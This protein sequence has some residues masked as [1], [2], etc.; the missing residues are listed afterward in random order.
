VRLYAY[1]D[2]SIDS[3]TK[4]VN[5]HPLP[6]INLGSD[7]V[8]CEGDN[9]TLDAGSGF[10]SYLWQNGNTTQSIIINNGG[11]FWVEVS[12]EF[13]CINR[14]S[15][16]LSL[17]PENYIYADTG[18]CLGDSI[19][20]GGSF[21][22]S[23]GVYI[24]TLNTAYG[25]D[26]IVEMTLYINDTFNIQNTVSICT[27]DSA[28]AGGAWQHQSGTYY[29]TWLS[30]DGCDSTVITEL[31]VD[32]IIQINLDE[33]ICEGDSVFASGQW[34]TES[35]IYQDTVT[36]ALGCDSIT[37]LELSVHP[38]FSTQTD[39]SICEGD[40]IYLG[41]MYRTLEG[42]Y[43]DNY[44]T[45]DGCDSLVI[46]QLSIDYPPYVELGNDTTL[47]SGNEYELNAYIPG[48]SYYWQ[49]GST[50]SYYFVR[51]EGAYF[52]SVNNQCGSASDTILITFDDL[53]CQI[54]VP[55][56]FTPDD[57]GLND[58]FI[59]LFN[60]NVTEYELIIFNRWGGIV[61]RTQN[62]SEGWKGIIDGK[63]APE[64]M[65]TWII[66]FRADNFSNNE[67]REEKGSVLLLR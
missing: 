7:T 58:T 12:N 39:T 33:D 34:Q 8:F 32:D 62:P 21:Q 57:D 6:A 56:A 59:P 18:L 64:G 51:E 23:A 48:A 66:N 29:D 63:P 40:S 5:I 47:Q 61:F 44:I 52:V 43:E 2:N 22:S 31:M 42:T 46:T 65:Y 49:D 10:A 60:C 55:N 13:G 37:T 30:T 20:L 1:F 27:G 17:V 3:T 15:I 41:N 9:Y 25:C 38:V 36:S 50:E 4:S 24:D 45:V 53:S 14:D 54:T 19:F 26:S 28:W 16:V 11:I 35:G 67:M